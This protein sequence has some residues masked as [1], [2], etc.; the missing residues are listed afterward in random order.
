LGYTSQETYGQPG[1]KIIIGDQEFASMFSP[2][3][4]E[5]KVLDTPAYRLYR[6]SGKGFPAAVKTI[7][8]I[9][10]STIRG[11]AFVFQDCSQEEN[12][13]AEL[14]HMEKL[15]AL[16][17]FQTSFAHEVRNPINNISTGLQ[18]MALNL[19]PDDPNQDAIS[20]LKQDCDRLAELMNTILSYT[21]TSQNEM[22][23]VD[24]D[25]MVNR[26]MERFKPKHLQANIK[27]HVQIDPS[28]SQVWGNRRA[29]EQV[30]VNLI[31]N[32][33]RVMKEN[34]GTLAVKIANA[35]SPEKV[36]V[37]EA[38]IAD[39]GPG[40]PKEE[41]ERLFNPYFTTNPNGNGLGL[42]ICGKIIE[43]HRGRIDMNTFPGGGTIFHIRI[44]AFKTKEKS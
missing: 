33:T 11:W 22:A 41:Q 20:R 3:A 19:P 30:Y 38:S 42:H 5:Y 4:P 44:P 1:G 14:K 39:T 18:Y 31:E 36:E 37:V 29:L 17:R 16:G 34:G 32:A 24:L 28:L 8:L 27:Q 12:M 10:A 35:V 15:A 23:P 25:Q 2:E 9:E 21:W 40:I 26:V 7:P 13:K 6:R 43:A